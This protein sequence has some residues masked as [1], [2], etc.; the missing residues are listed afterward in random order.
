[1]QKGVLNQVPQFVELFVIVPLLLSISLWRNLSFHTLL[2]G[3]LN[4]CVAVIPLVSQQIFCRQALNEFASLRAIC[5]G[6]CR[7]KYSDRHTMRIHGQVQLC[8]E[9]PFV[10][11]ISWLP[12][13]APAA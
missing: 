10:S 3:L 5:C 6:T 2:G 8:I 1:M 11:P 7:D 4:D 12:P 9:P 13:F